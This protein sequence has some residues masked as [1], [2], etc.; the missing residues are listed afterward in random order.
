VPGTELGR[1]AGNVVAK[2]LAKKRHRIRYSH[3]RFEFEYG[4]RS[5]SRK[6]ASSC[7]G[8]KRGAR[9]DKLRKRE[10]GMAE[11]SSD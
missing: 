1:C 6:F 7:D 9:A 11:A 2:K 10:K 8:S 3:R 5:A 4:S